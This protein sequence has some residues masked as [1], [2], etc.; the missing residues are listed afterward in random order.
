MS[1]RSIKYRP[2]FPLP[3]E[4][5]ASTIGSSLNLS[6]IG[7]SPQRTRRINQ[8]CVPSKASAGAKDTGGLARAQT[9][10]AVPITHKTKRTRLERDEFGLPKPEA[11]IPKVTY[12][13]VGTTPLGEA[14]P[15]SPTGAAPLERQVDPIRISPYYI[16]MG[17]EEDYLQPLAMGG[18]TKV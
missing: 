11:K 7:R 6:E 8:S 13:Q 14:V 16:A 1:P 10:A 12:T 15:A 5:T 17:T 2:R 4:S 9:S 18:K 3:S